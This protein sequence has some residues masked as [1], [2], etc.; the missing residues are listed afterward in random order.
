M[1]EV[2][3]RIEEKKKSERQKCECPKCGGKCYIG[4][5]IGGIPD[6]TRRKCPKCKGRGW[7]WC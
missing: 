7:I 2:T 1:T 3:I 5:T 4:L 6:I